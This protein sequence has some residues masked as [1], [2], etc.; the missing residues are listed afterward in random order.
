[1]KGWIGWLLLGLSLLLVGA[2]YRNMR[3]EPETEE[4]SRAIVCSGDRS[5]VLMSDRPGIVRT[6]FVRRRYQWL[7]SEG[8]IVV[9][10]HREFYVAGTWTCQATPG[11]L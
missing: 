2:G 11:A 4:L 7:T 1:M 3:A 8:T 9:A 6:D 10:C 5:C